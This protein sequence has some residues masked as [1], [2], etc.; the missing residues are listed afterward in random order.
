MSSCIVIK[1]GGHGEDV[2]KMINFWHKVQLWATEMGNAYGE[3]FK[4]T[5]ENLHDQ[6]GLGNINCEPCMWVGKWFASGQH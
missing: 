5:T 6:L 4:L 1:V 2:S 3:D